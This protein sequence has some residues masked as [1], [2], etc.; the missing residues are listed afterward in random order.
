M[1]KLLLVS[2]CLPSKEHAGGQRLLDMYHELRRIQPD[3]YVVL[4]ARDSGFIDFSLLDEIFDEVHLVSGEKIS[5]KSFLDKIF[6]LSDFDVIDLCF[7]G[8]GSLIAICRSRWPCALLIF[9]PMESQ[10]RSAKILLEK[11]GLFFL[12]C[13]KNILKSIFLAMQEISYVIR[14]DKVVTVSNSDRDALAFLKKQD[15]VFSIP[16]CIPTY[17]SSK[18]ISIHE[19]HARSVEKKVVFFAYFGSKTNQEALLWFLRKVHP[20]ILEEV[21]DYKFSV[22][23]NGLDEDLIDDFGLAQ[24]E[25]VGSVPSIAE[26]V[27]GA[28]LGISP[29]LSGAGIRGKIHHYAAFGLPCVASPIAC[30]GLLYVNGES[31]C[32]AESAHDFA[33]SCINLLKNEEFRLRVA[34]NA[35]HI[36]HSNYQW[37][38]WHDRILSIYE[39]NR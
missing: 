22:V 17:I 3:L 7:H 6:S 14:V 24:V 25:F 28:L 19:M 2:D 26:A 30:E 23:G 8:V 38:A 32:I 35:M 16:T 18:E 36:C 10:L 29:A 33:M 4:I 21:P 9:S 37:P 20:I 34:K 31:I 39:L 11:E 12:R 1:K 13:W 15:K 27:D 5:K